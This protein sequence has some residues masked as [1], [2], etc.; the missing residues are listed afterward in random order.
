MTIT[1]LERS[2]DLPLEVP[3][4]AAEG[5]PS[6]PAPS[7]RRPRRQRRRLLVAAAC[8]G[9]LFLLGYVPRRTQRAALDEALRTAAA[10]PASVVTVLPVSAPAERPLVLPGSIEP[11]ETASVHSRASG[12]VKEWLVD[13]GERVVA[14]QRLATL[15]TPELE[16]EIDQAHATLARSVASV[17]QAEA[18]AE[19][20][21]STL[22]RQVALA[23][24]GLVSQQDL[25]RD[26]ARAHVDAAN[27][28]VARAE[29]LARAAE[30][31]RLEQLQ[32]FAQIVAPFAGTVSARRVERG[33]LVSGGASGPLFEIVATDSVRVQL[34]VPQSLA[35]DVTP[36]S[37]V[38]LRV[39]EYPDAVFSGTLA[40][41]SGTLDP[42]S[43]TL[44]AEA[45][46]SN[47]DGRLLPGMYA[48]VT[49]RVKRGRP[50]FLLPATALVTGANGTSVAT[51]LE[52]GTVRHVAV[53]IARD[54]GAEIEVRRGLS[55]SEQV[56]RAPGPRI[57]DGARVRASDKGRI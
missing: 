24:E 10:E 34:Q 42:S 20:S 35:P 39:D 53:D 27:I 22:E 3:P 6:S 33:A 49:L 48:S 26:R 1:S 2:S 32:R 14:G 40:R 54:L 11:L 18:S 25:A 57:T 55:G 41:T 17:T 21:A 31:A 30:L 43:R 37:S 56:I 45:V 9:A 46:V 15:D 13:I 29:R 44:R 51:V 16:R 52:D 38:E 12:F 5:A 50:S 23:R 36:G 19:Y 47:A 28:R 8:L 4:P 7:L